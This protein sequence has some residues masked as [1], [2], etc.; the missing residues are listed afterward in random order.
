MA[1]KIQYRAVS[2]EHMTPAVRASTLTRAKK[3][4]VAIDITKTKMMTDSPGK[5]VNVLPDGECST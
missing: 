4:V 1:R 2:I 5:M 3:L